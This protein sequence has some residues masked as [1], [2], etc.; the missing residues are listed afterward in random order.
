MVLIGPWSILSIPSCL[1]SLLPQHKSPS[2][3]WHSSFSPMK[4]V[5]GLPLLHINVMS[6][7]KATSDTSI[8][9]VY[10]CTKTIVVDQAVRLKPINISDMHFEGKLLNI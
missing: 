10:D 6:T 5:L 8:F 4:G 7:H 1:F 2:S 9:A 3:L